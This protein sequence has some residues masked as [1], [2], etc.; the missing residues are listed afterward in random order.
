VAFK[1]VE[2]IHL[3]KIELYDVWYKDILKGINLRVDDGVVALI[4]PNGAGKTTILKVVVK[5]LK[6]DRGRVVVPEKVGSSWQNPYYSFTKPTVVEEFLEYLGSV[7]EVEEFLGNYGLKHLLSKYTF[8]LSVG[9]ARL[10]SILLAVV[11]GPEA[12]VLDEPTNGLSLRE[13]YTVSEL[14][15]S[16]KIPV[17]IASHDL[18]FILMTSDYVYVVNDGHIVCGG[19]TLDIFYSDVLQHIGFPEPEVVRVGKELGLRLRCI[20]EV[21]S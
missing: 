9:Q 18:D 6:P 11:W 15:R 3:A 4:G 19:S 13:R 5:A 10:V 16:I 8:K 7:R 12:L 2:V 21:K 1:Y 20:D 17:V 14:L